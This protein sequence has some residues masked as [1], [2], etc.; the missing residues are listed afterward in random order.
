M[1]NA[2]DTSA[3]SFVPSRATLVA[4]R[5]QIVARIDFM[6]EDFSGCDWCCGGGDE[7]M[8]YHSDRLKALAAILGAL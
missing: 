1:L 5:E 4:E 3:L 6:Y 2:T 8:A 7:E